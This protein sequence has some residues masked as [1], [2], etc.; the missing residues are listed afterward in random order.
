MPPKLGNDIG[1][2]RIGVE[3]VL[4]LKTTL[5]NSPPSCKGLQA[6]VVPMRRADRGKRL[7]LAVACRSHYLL[8]VRS[9]YCVRGKRGS[10]YGVDRSRRNSFY[11][12]LLSIVRG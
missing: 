3:E 2:K 8:C 12:S 7:A 1:H 6:A 9:T 5:L 11:F 4:V 10:I